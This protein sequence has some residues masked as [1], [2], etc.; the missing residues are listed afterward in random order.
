MDF[1]WTKEQLAL[2]SKIVEFAQQE[3]NVDVADHDRSGSFSY[4]KWRKCAA[5]GIQ[6][7]NLSVDY[8]GSGYDLMTT[9]LAMEG[10]GYG[11]RDNGLAFALNA[12]MWSIQPTLAQFGTEKQKQTYLPTLSRGEKIGC[13]AMTEPSSG[14]DA[15]SLRTT[16]QKCDQGYVLN[17]EKTLTTFGP[18]ADFA[19]I[20]ASTNPDHGKW[21][22]T[23]FIVDTTSEGFQASPVREKMGL[24]T[25]PIGD[26]KLTDCVVPVENRLGP[27]GA[28][29]SIFNSSQEWERAC[30]LA[31]QLGSLQRQLETSVAYARERQQF[32]QAIGKFQSVSNRIAEMKLRLETARLLTYRA[33]WLKQQGQPVMLDAAL[34]NWHLGECFV[35]SSLDAIRIH[36]GKGYLTEHEIERD[37]RDAIGGP[38]YGGTTDIQRNIVARLLGV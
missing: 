23:A 11:C 32:G 22:V 15:Y 6:G 26:L 33:A 31:S 25:V 8:G 4:D 37:L 7:L 1:S 20:F 38:L 9:V 27:E 30:I 21:G 24:R 28:G 3:L 36:G 12:Q 5:F 13:Y 19:I 10:F 17:G 35:E 16:A 34:A 2:K 29:A 14:S 18:I